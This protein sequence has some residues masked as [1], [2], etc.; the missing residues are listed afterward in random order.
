MLRIFVSD[1]PYSQPERQERQIRFT[2]DDLSDG[3]LDAVKRQL[4]FSEDRSWEN[5]SKIATR[6][7]QGGKY[8]N[9]GQRAIEL[10][11]SKAKGTGPKKTKV[12][13]DDRWRDQQSFLK[14]PERHAGP[15][16]L[17]RY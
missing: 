17:S 1:D 3:V 10:K 9:K 4:H 11:K 16:G 8:C 6:F 2:R 13:P 15:G 7:L 12:A 5:Q 14:W